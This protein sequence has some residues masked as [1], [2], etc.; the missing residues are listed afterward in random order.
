MACHIER[1]KF[2]ATL[3]GAA[4]AWPLM[5]RHR[6]RIIDSA[7]DHGLATI[8][9]FRGHL[10]ASAALMCSSARQDGIDLRCICS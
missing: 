4:V 3:G 2:L 9:A 8:Y 10:I 5:F 7:M 6:R 1:R